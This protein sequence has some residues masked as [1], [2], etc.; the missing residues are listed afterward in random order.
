MLK[1]W[2]VMQGH[3]M[4]VHTVCDLST[5][6]TPLAHQRAAS[7][8]S[9]VSWQQGLHGLQLAAAGVRPSLPRPC[10]LGRRAAWDQVDL[11][12]FTVKLEKET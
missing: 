9:A 3:E 6:L 1:G 5:C 8:L 2:H 4:G 10:W 12:E 7:P 11:T